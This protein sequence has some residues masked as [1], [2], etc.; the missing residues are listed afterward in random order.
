MAR[1]VAGAYLLIALAFFLVKTV[2]VNGLYQVA[3]GV[4]IVVGLVS[5]V[6]AAI[7]VLDA[8]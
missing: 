7:V 5:L 1:K 3:Q 2:E 8:R 6:V 4:A